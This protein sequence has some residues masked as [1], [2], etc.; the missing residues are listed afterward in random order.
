MH[1]RVDI[2]DVRNKRMDMIGSQIC[3]RCKRARGYSMLSKAE[4]E[5]PDI[6]I[7]DSRKR[8]EGIGN[9]SQ[10]IVVRRRS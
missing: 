6:L 2:A 7:T 1:A 3:N 10:G 8:K 4:A 9:A 5:M